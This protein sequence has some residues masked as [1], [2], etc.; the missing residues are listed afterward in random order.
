ML[1]HLVIRNAKSP[2][3]KIRSRLKFVELFPQRLT[4]V[5]E[6]VLRILLTPGQRT[7]K[8]VDPPRMLDVQRNEFVNALDLVHPSLLAWRLE[9]G[10]ETTVYRIWTHI[11]AVGVLKK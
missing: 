7:H 5:L 11:L 6:N 10:L 1:Q 8:V 9:I 3:Q 4:D 2:H